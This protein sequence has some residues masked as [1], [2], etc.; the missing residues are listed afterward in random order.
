VRI[1]LLPICFALAAALT[2]L[3]GCGKAP[4]PASVSSAPASGAPA[5]ASAGPEKPLPPVKTSAGDIPD[6]QVFV[7]YRSTSGKYSIDAPE[8]WART[9]NGADVKFTAQFDG[10]QVAVH[11]SAAPPTTD[12]VQREQV[13]AIQKIGRAVTIEGV[14]AATLANGMAVVTIEYSSNSDPDPVTG[15]QVRLSNVSWLFY[16]QGLAAALTLWAPS[17]TDNVDQWK[18]I[19]ESF[20]WQ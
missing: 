6:T 3:A 12:S 10:E 4:A 19:S 20:R 9:E 5:L 11:A 7:T 15:K 16:R 2:L 18:R 14:K 8:G 1:T 17:G 13:P